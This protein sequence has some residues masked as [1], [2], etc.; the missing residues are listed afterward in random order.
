MHAAQRR[1]AWWFL[2]PALGVLVLFFLL[3]VCAGFALAFTDF[4]IYALGD[5]RLLRFA[6][7]D[8]FTALAGSPQF[9]R[10]L[11]NTLYFCIVGGCASIAVSLA[12]ALLL[13]H[14]LARFKPLWRTALF[15]PVVTTL[16][17][18]AVVW[19]Y[20]YHP[21]YGLI[22]YGLQSLG[23]GPID[24]LGDPRWAMPALILMAVWKNFGFNM[25][26]F[27]A[28]LQGIPASLYEAARLDGAGPWQRFVHVTL[29]MLRPTFVFV[30][31]TTVVGYL[32]LF[33]EP[34]VM[35]RGGPSD[36]TLSV[37]LLMYDQGFRWWNMGYAAA[38]AVVV[39]ALIAA[40]SALQMRLLRVRAA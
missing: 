29:P 6:G 33:A 40:V 9:W 1:A 5:R 28:G 39:F 21:R 37:M 14:R 17:A 18:V 10:A 19:R 38:I 16:V 27:V 20:L 11:G 7:L 3:P 30:L 32:Q 24:W 26:I 34:Y 15:V 36:A 13:D 35:T 2:A 31:V 22:N 4:D 8:N 23:I 12:A 25:V